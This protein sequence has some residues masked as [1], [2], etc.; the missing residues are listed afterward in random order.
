M[1]AGRGLNSG[2]ERPDPDTSAREAARK[3]LNLSCIS[4]EH[5]LKPGIETRLKCI[6]SVTN[7][8]GE[9]NHAKLRS[10][11]D[12][13]IKSGDKDG[14]EV[15]IGEL[16]QQ[17][18]SLDNFMG[19]SATKTDCEKVWALAKHAAEHHAKYGEAELPKI[20]ERYLPYKD[21]KEFFEA[22]SHEIEPAR[23][24]VFVLIHK[25]SRKLENLDAAADQNYELLIGSFYDFVVA[26]A[27]GHL[28]LGE[29][30]YTSEYYEHFNSLDEKIVS[31]N[32]SMGER[33]T[34][35]GEFNHEL[36]QKY[37]GMLEV[38]RE[39]RDLSKVENIILLCKDELT[40]FDE[41]ILEISDLEKNN[42]KADELYN[43][44]LD[45]VEKYKRLT[46]GTL[47][48]ELGIGYYPDIKLDLIALRTQ[49]EIC[50][51]ELL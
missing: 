15:L 14:I 40:F 50:K 5:G 8:V 25:L 30:W 41:R 36:T 17:E 33:L 2:G 10:R 13:L 11:A 39:N 16:A 46:G 29:D 3:N 28:Q 47:E 44:F 42:N 22:H 1:K 38:A 19:S 21:A 45:H 48:V 6:D 26:T 34:E 51:N 7:S 37:H 9:D 23:K 12:E 49:I 4:I 27:G 24:F 31:L 20:L 32:T 35:K 18:Y 43:T